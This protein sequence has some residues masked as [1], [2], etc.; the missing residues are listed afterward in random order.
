MD[1]TPAITSSPGSK[2]RLWLMRL[3]AMIFVP[4]LVLGCIEIGLRLG[5]YGYDPGL[6]KQIQINGH[7]FFVPNE[8]FG[9]R[10]FP[11]AL[12]RTPEPFRF[13]AERATNSYRIFLLGESAAN[14][15]PD[16]TYGVGRYLETLLRERYPGTDFQVV[17][18]AMTAIDSSTILP[19]ARECARHQGDLWVIY[20]GNNEMV[21]PFGAATSYGLRALNRGVIRAILAIKTTRMGQLLDSVIGSWRSHSSTPQKWGGMEMFVKNR[22]SHD[23]PARRRGYTNF[24]GNLEDILRAAHGA[25]V[26]VVLSTVAVNLKDCAPFA[27]LHRAGLSR[28]QA[29]AWNQIYAEGIEREA[30][31]AYQQALTQYQKVA[32]I[33]PQFADLQFRMGTCELALAHPEPARQAFELARDYDA[34]PF[35]ADTSINSMIKE[36]AAL[37][38]G[39]GVFLVDAAAALA[40][41][42]PDG[43]PGLE[44]FFEHVHLNFA[45]NY[46]LAVHFAEQARKLLPGSIT[47]RDGGNWASADLCDRRLAVTVWDRQRIWQP[48]MSR[49]TSPPFTGQFNHTANL[50]A[51][52]AKLNEARVAMDTQTPE[53]A[54][55]MYEQALA[56]NP[57]DYFLHGNF[58]RFLEKGGYLA[59]AITEA[60]RCC[61]LVPQL[62]G[63]YYYTGLL[64]V[65]AGQTA[66]ASEYFSRALAIRSDYAEAQNEMGQILADRQKT[67]EAM[68]WFK[69]AIRS[70]PAY[71]ESYLN[72]GFLQ[73][74]LGQNEAAMASYQKAAK[75]EPEGP[76]DYFYRAN[77]A[78]TRYR[79]DEAM[80][81]LRA[82]VRA[83]PEFWQARYQLGIQ[84]A[85]KGETADAQTQL[86]EAIRYRPD[87]S[88]AHFYLGTVLFAQGKPDQALA[89]FR[90]ALQLDPTNASARQ[91]IASIERLSPHTP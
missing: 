21:G 70:N 31:G 10:F 33:D 14:G 45:G 15:D 6:F 75:L 8:K 86:A 9:Y 73:Q 35:R 3:C 46:L 30:A 40:Q 82:V 88:Q 56:S 22:L 62:P 72:L 55:A 61:E 5:G 37:H 74:G 20:M 17:S 26:P 19:I 60:K 36:I 84:L 18:V 48:I 77:L 53:Q 81:C 13:P 16:P 57:D 69:R 52:E 80:A 41:E 27:S 24:K 85:A 66:E 44:L 71:V 54:R 89:A 91:Q 58:Q 28:E 43:I 67:S 50:K 12:A 90:T 79:W 29:S 59:Q 42:S 23:D 65:R 4:L 7:S 64:L 34:L 39:Q 83:K 32:Q 38:A 51:Y 11:P 2:G 47:A 1:K 63:G 68:A 76:S 49:V 87:F 78:A 25:G